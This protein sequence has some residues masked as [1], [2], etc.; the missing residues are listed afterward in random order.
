MVSSLPGRPAA[1]YLLLSVVSRLLPHDTIRGSGEPIFPLNAVTIPRHIKSV[2]PVSEGHATRPAPPNLALGFSPRTD[3]NQIARARES[4][5]LAPKGRI[6]G[7]D[8][9]CR[10]RFGETMGSDRCRCVHCHAQCPQAVSSSCPSHN[11]ERPMRLGHSNAFSTFHIQVERILPLKPSG[12]KPP[13]MT[14]RAGLP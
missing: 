3:G 1:G 5:E 11:S 4:T 14:P 8:S 2:A 13:A 9:D 7:G 12:K 10:V 6:A